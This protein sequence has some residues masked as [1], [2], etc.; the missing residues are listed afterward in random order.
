MKEYICD[1][2]NEK[3]V[4]NYTISNPRN[5]AEKHK[6]IVLQNVEKAQD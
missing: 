4:R 1:E 3:F 5:V 6:N 2:Y